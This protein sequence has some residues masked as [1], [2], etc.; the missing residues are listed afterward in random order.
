MIIAKGDSGATSHYWRERDK[1][2]LHK[3]KNA[4]GPT[5]TLPNNTTI[6]S[7]SCGRLPL[8][9]SLSP[10][11][12]TTSILPNLQI[13]SLISLGQLCDDDCQVLLNKKSLFVVK[14]DN[15]VMEGFR[16][17]SD[18]LWDIPIHNPN[19]LKSNNTT[20]PQ[21]AGLY[22]TSSLKLPPSPFISK[23]NKKPKAPKY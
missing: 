4:P 11:A 18:R 23:Q 22:G 20:V 21:N 8:H 2:C 6:T 12:T 1:S 14:N 3:I 19:L 17:E 10:Q 16:N 7:T 15:V 5:V 13:S 9:E